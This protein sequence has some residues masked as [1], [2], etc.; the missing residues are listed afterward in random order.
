MAS[1]PGEGVYKST[2]E[3][4]VDL[5]GASFLYLNWITPRLTMDKKR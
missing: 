4:Y 1:G 2:A 5:G 3:A